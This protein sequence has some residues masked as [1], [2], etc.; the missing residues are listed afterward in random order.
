[1]WQTIQ[2]VWQK[3]QLVG[4]PPHQLYRKLQ[5]WWCPGQ[6]TAAHRNR[7]AQTAAAAPSSPEV[8]PELRDSE[9][10]H[11]RPPALAKSTDL[12]SHYVG[13]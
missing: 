11:H 5:P 12:Q 6:N 10:W 9:R 7:P 3:T 8:G 13:M 2:L 1:M 4:Q